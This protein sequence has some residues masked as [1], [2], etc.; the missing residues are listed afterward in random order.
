MS[1]INLAQA[2][3]V[4]NKLIQDL[5]QTIVTTISNNSKN[6]AQKS[7]YDTKELIETIPEKINKVVNIK[8]KIHAASEPIRDKIF[9]LS[10]MKA[11]L[12]LLKNMSTK[13]GT[14]NDRYESTVPQEFIVSINELEKQEMVNALVLQIEELQASIDTFNALTLIT[15]D[16]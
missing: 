4:K 16:A 7:Y 5:K 13:E 8:T 10:E 11:Y 14:F 1:Q 6:A 15:Y 9:S 2:L 12:T 3:R